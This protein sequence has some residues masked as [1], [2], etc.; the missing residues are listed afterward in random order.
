M[1]GQIWN[2]YRRYWRESLAAFLFSSA[3]VVGLIVYFKDTLT[4]R[5][6]LSIT[7]GSRERLAPNLRGGSRPRQGSRG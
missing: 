4:I 6:E 7:G 3:L 5:S 1:A 2:N